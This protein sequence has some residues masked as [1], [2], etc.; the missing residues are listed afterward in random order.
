[1]RVPDR[2]VD[3]II[4]AICNSGTGIAKLLLMT[5]QI[6]QNEFPFRPNLVSSQKA[7][8]PASTLSLG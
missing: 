6:S 1:M 5:A 2:Y 4:L 7:S 8:N 3:S